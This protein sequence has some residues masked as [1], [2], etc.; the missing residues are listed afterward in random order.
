[1]IRE[2]PGMVSSPFASTLSIF[3][4]LLKLAPT[5]WVVLKNMLTSTARFEKHGA[6]RRD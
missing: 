1:M 2:P 6:L 5:G 3:R 4:A